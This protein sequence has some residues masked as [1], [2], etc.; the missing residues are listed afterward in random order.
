[1]IR[2]LLRRGSGEFRIHVEHHGRVEFWLS[3]V[4]GR[5]L[6]ALPSLEATRPGEYRP[7]IDFRDMAD[8]AYIV[9]AQQ[10]ERGESVVVVRQ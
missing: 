9:H 2:T 8:G 10:M 1:L 6:L 4:A 5:R 7:P 3:D